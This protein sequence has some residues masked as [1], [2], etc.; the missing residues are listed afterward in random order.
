MS[1]LLPDDPPEFHSAEALFQHYADLR[2]RT[3]AAARS[4]VIAM[5]ARR[6]RP[7]PVEA[8]PL[9]PAAPAGTA[10]FSH[11]APLDPRHSFAQFCAGDSNRMA[12]AAA[13]ALVQRPE[14]A[15]AYSPLYLHSRPGLGKT[16]LLQAI[17]GE[18]GSVALY[19]TAERL[20]YGC[21]L[22]AKER[23]IEAYHQALRAADVLLIDD[24]QQIAAPLARNTLGTVLNAMS[25]AGK[26]VVL[27]ASVPPDELEGFD[28]WQR[29]RLSAGLVL[30]ILPPEPETR[31]AILAQN[32]AARGA[33]GKASPEV[34]ALIAGLPGL[35]GR[36]LEAALTRV[37]AHAEI[38]GAPLGLADAE[39][40][41]GDLARGRRPEPVRLDDILRLI[42]RHYGISR[43]DLLS[44]RRTANLVRPRQIAMY[45]AK[46]LT[47]RSL[48][49]IGRRFGGR[50]HT[51]VLHAVRKLTGLVESDAEIATEVRRLEIELREGRA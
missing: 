6:P 24:V 38:T 32:C 8:P 15:R 7:A 9:A 46:T 35:S 11:A 42:T 22:A 45:L 41:L 50:D 26:H 10:S 33:E 4:S 17:A 30:E 51:T 23:K 34:L 39:A 29:S 2:A 20:M 36:D 27:G 13:L 16:H 19:L 21:L 28:G 5:T 40:M 31:L 1:G 3:Q 47:L 18:A 49:E 37:V 43:A 25:D 44:Q 48:P 12:H 14:T